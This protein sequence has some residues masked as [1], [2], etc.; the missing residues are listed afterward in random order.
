[1]SCER[2]SWF[3]EATLPTN[4]G[5]YRCLVYRFEDGF[6][7]VALVMGNV[8][9]RSSVLCRIQSECL[10]G[11]VFGSLRCDCKHQLDLALAKIG[12]EGFGILL[13]LRQEGRGIGLGNKI[14]AYRLQE[15]GVDTV[16]A[17]RILGFP[18]DGRD[19]YCAVRILRDL[20][21]ASVKLLTNNPHK[22]DSLVNAGIH[23][24]ERLSHVAEIPKTAKNYMMVKGKRM[25]HFLEWSK[26]P[27]ETFD[28]IQ[29][30]GRF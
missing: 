30:D 1:M 25:G 9:N 2:G 13:Y 23:V 24:V 10:T 18:D 5:T 15:N 22:V 8:H 7:H 19:F 12:D 27:Q 21:V 6:E 20:K 14:R 28:I 3:A 16:D 26:L 29:L 4:F 11:E 17:N